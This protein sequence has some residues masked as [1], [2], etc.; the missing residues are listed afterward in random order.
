MD[1]SEVYINTSA[2]TDGALLKVGD[3]YYRAMNGNKPD[4]YLL[5]KI[6]LHQTD[7]IELVEVN[8]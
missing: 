6:E 3:N 7:D 2:T 4:K 8:Q 5:E 1:K